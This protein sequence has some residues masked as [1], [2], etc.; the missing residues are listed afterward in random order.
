M[1]RRIVIGTQTS[2]DPEHII[3]E[4]VPLQNKRNNVKQYNLAFTNR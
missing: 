4:V 3:L 1:H 2:F